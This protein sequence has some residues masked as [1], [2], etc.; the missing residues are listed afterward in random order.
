M[1]SKFSEAFCPDGEIN[2]FA[3]DPNC[4]GQGIGTLLLS[5]LERLEKGK[6][7]FLYTDSGST[8]QFYPKRG[9]TESG[10]SS[11][12]LEINQKTVPLTCFLYSKRL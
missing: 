10:K 1:L 2:F 11:I 7:I 6:L 3:A 5:E 9:F 8:Y 4:K 12:S